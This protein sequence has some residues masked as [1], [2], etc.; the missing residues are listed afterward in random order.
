MSEHEAR[1]YIRFR[2]RV[3][4]GSLSGFASHRGCSPAYVSKLLDI[5]RT[6]EIPQWLLDEAGLTR[7]VSY[8]A[9]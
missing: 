7:T 6:K 1:E 9:A 3:K 5:L 2:L 4:Y 8:T